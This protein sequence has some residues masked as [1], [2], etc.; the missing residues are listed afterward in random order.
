MLLALLIAP[1]LAHRAYAQGPNDSSEVVIELES[2]GLNNLARQGSWTPVRLALTDHGDHGERARRAMVSV[3]IP[4]ADGDKS[5]IS[6]EVTLNLGMPTVVWL[7]MRLPFHFDSSDTFTI[8]VREVNEDG[9]PGREIAASVER[10]TNFLDRD[11]GAIGIVGARK[12]TLYRY[13]Q[14]Y[15]AAQVSSNPVG[16]EVTRFFDQIRPADMPDRWMGLDIF[17]SLVWIDGDPLA[18]SADQAN[19]IVEWV[20]RGGHLVIV[21][22]PVGSPWDTQHLLWPLRPDVRAYKWEDV[23]LSDTDSAGG[24]LAHLT[25]I[26]DLAVPIARRDGTEE[27]MRPYPR[28]T[29]NLFEPLRSDGQTEGVT[30]SQTDTIPLMEIDATTVDGDSR[31]MAVVV[32]KHYGHGHITGIGIP[33][34]DPQINGLGLPDPEIF[35]NRVLGFRQDTPDDFEIDTVVNNKTAQFSGRDGPFHLSAPIPTAINLQRRAGSG[36]LLAIVVFIAY[37]V[38]S[39]PACFAWLKAKNKTHFSWLAFVGVA[40]IF[41]MTSWLGARALRSSEIKPLHLTVLDHVAGGRFHRTTSYFTVALAGYGERVVRVGE[42]EDTPNHDTLAPFDAPGA[43]QQTFPDHRTYVVRAASPYEIPAPARSTSKQFVSQW[44]GSPMSSWGMPN[45]LRDEDEPYAIYREATEPNK[46]A[47]ELH[48]IVQ[49]TLPGPLT[50]VRIYHVT[51]KANPSSR[52]P[53]GIGVPSGAPQLRVH[54]VDISNPQGGSAWAPNTPLDFSTMRMA[55]NTMWGP[56]T[57]TVMTRL[58][59]T[60]KNTSALRYTGQGGTSPKDR[61]R[62]LEL[63]CLFNLIDPPAWAGQRGGMDQPRFVRTMGRDL[64]MSQWFTRPCIIITGFVEGATLPF[65]AYVDDEQLV[66]ADINSLT[67]VR[68]VFPLR[69]ETEALGLR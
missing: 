43:N 62:I 31:R 5:L 65:P 68:W 47:I 19:A 9:D 20:E 1:C 69:V 8:I 33:I 21:F 28:L 30:W 59:D 48:G 46:P 22:P 41:T 60:A 38:V 54:A 25:R 32:R 66:E 58:Q 42:G 23:E 16:H 35:W 39:G 2:F 64:D 49:H 55:D 17:D 18:L 37:W 45:Y 50:D 51:N 3:E 52:M 53:R 15:T 4:D 40:A 29:L 44:L 11:M 7:Y 63:L 14:I 34:N 12:G 26:Q 61:K 13:E 36:L 67:F 27:R 56:D 6:R 24:L 57:K 10:P